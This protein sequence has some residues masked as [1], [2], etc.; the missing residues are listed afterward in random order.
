[1]FSPH[2]RICSSITE[3]GSDLKNKTQT[4]NNDLSK[5]DIQQPWCLFLAVDVVISKLK[6]HA[7]DSII[8]LSK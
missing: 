2:K 7:R 1:M 6:N 4:E 3:E 8:L 5:Y